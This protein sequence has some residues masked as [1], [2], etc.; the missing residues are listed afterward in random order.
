MSDY[1]SNVPISRPRNTGWEV[2]WDCNG[3]CWSNDYGI[4]FDVVDD[5]VPLRKPARMIGRNG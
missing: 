4:F 5:M 1:V 3:L 2:S